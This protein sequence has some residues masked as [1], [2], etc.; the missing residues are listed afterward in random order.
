LSERRSFAPPREVLSGLG[1][2]ALWVGAVGAA[3]SIAGLFVD[4]EQFFRSYLVGWLLWVGVALGCLAILLID[5]LAGGRWG[6]MVRRTMEAAASTLPALGLLMIPIL[7]GLPSIF[8]W[9]RPE[10]VAADELIQKK[11]AYLDSGFFIGRAALYFAIWSGA[12]LVMR[13]LSLKQDRTADPLLAQRLRTLAA[14]FLGL[15][16]LAAT[17]ASVD[18][19]MSLDPHWFSSLYGVYFLG[20]VGVS[21]FSFLILVASVLARHEP[22]APLFTR[23]HF[24]DYGKFLLAFVML[25]TYFAVSQLLIVWSANLPEEITWYLDRQRGGWIYL[26][27]AIA[28]LHF[29]LPFLILLSADVKKKARR[30]AAVAGLLIVMRWVDLYWQAAPSFHPA[31]TLHWLDLATVIGVGGLWLALFFRQLGLHPLL[32]LNAP[33]LEEV[34]ADE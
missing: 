25:W 24:H 20:G 6:V 4:R 32:P 29:A 8:V 2:R 33:R 19:L 28:L 31:L 15:L 14:P 17:F 27:I 1:R 10:V 13:G 5:H 21:G 26:S 30:L 9:A 3:A 7:L 16:A 34:L 12:T 11:A 18:W 23:T 22:L